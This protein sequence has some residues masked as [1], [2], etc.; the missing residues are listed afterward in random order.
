MQVPFDLTQLCAQLLGSPHREGKQAAN[1]SPIL[2]A[3]PLRL[4]GLAEMWFIAKVTLPIKTEKLEPEQ[5]RVPVNMF[6]FHSSK[7]DMSSF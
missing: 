2:W 6:S 1:K 3:Y 7:K 4:G 5:L